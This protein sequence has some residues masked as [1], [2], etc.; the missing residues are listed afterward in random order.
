MTRW[1]GC[2][3]VDTSGTVCV[4]PMHKQGS[5]FQPLRK[6]NLFILPPPFL[7]CLLIWAFEFPS[8][9]SEA[10]NAKRY[11]PSVLWSPFFSR[12]S[13]SPHRHALLATINKERREE[14]PIFQ[15]SNV[16]NTLIRLNQQ[17]C[18]PRSACKSNEVSIFITCT[19]S[20][21]AV[22]LCCT[23]SYLLMD[24]KPAYVSA[25]ILYSSIGMFGSPLVSWLKLVRLKSFS[26]PLVWKQELKCIKRALKSLFSLPFSSLFS[27]LSLLS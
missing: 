11:T 22:V 20:H 15:F 23:Y 25:I 2:F 24:I 14:E 9:I 17:H 5:Q 10:S 21:N 27:L 6:R 1:R 19:I 8:Y 3:E 7:N 18:L 4:I 26:H 13:D 12:N 16:N